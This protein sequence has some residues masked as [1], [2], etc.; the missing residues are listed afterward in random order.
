VPAAHVCARPDAR[1]SDTV[2]W[3]FAIGNAPD[4]ERSGAQ[5]RA[6]AATLPLQTVCLRTMSWELALK[7]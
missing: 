3:R 2:V 7:A 4:A 5:F 6:H 1:A